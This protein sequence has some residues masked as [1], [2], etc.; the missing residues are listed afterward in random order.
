MTSVEKVEKKEKN[1]LKSGLKLSFLTLLSRILGVIRE[2]TKA[3]FLGTS[4]YADAFGIAFM[5]PN[6]LR[7]LF[8]ENSISVAFVPTFKGYLQK[9]TGAENTP[10]EAER[11]KEAQEFINATFTLI[12]FLTTCVV[13]LG[14]VFTPL[15]VRLFYAGET[16]SMIGETSIL[17]RIMFPYLLVISI[18]AFFQGV[19][20]T[21]KIFSPSGFTP[22]LFNLCVIA[23][24]YI[25]S[26]FMENPARA[27][28][29]GVMVGGCIQALFQLPFVLKTGWKVSFTG[30]KNAFTNPG[31]R[32]VVALVVPT[33]IGMA[34]Y[35]LNDL[36]SSALANWVGEGILSSLQYS[37]RL[38]ELILGVF[39]VTI[40]TIILPDLSGFAKEKKWEEYNA[41]LITALKVIAMICIPITFYSLITGR[42]IICLVYKS[43]RFDDTSV[44]LTMQA[45]QMHIIGLFFI[46]VNR[47]LSP[48]FYAQEKPKLPTYAGLISFGVNIILAFVLSFSLKGRGIALALTISSFVNMAAL[49]IF[50]KG[51]KTT[52]TKKVAL[53]T[54]FYSLKMVVF[55]A[56]ASVPC[57]FL[58]PVLVE[59]FAHLGRF[60]GNG[61]P[62]L[63]TA[64]V[65]FVSGVA[66]LIISKDS[67]AMIIIR[68]FKRR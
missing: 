43:N 55:S 11:R 12:T 32:R 22:V 17:T 10:E 53:S 13:L 34:S 60:L 26:N 3:R 30:I 61:I 27:M 68:K 54:V 20:N 44:A 37:L 2:A 63:I 58:H 1:I 45:F 9:L 5:I 25:L 8:A 59:K 4:A 66:C 23:G 49:F 33:I 46:A 19:L 21:L 39:A 51:L 41:M 35:Q 65:F 62:I 18:A 14:I 31:T 29:C 67:V 47:V 7:R 56:I 36:V 52:D 64:A 57:Y 50:L 42:Q 24:T 38:Q 15:I 40:G 6:L 28:S 48:A 16:V